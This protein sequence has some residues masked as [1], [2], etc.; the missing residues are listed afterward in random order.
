MD[1]L[2]NFLD[3]EHCV[4][5]IKRKDCRICTAVVDWTQA[6]WS[7]ELYCWSL[8]ALFPCTKGSRLALTEKEALYHVAKW[9]WLFLPFPGALLLLSLLCCVPRTGH[10]DLLTPWTRRCLPS[11]HHSSLSWPLV[12]ASRAWRGCLYAPF[13]MD[14]HECLQFCFISCVT[15]VFINKWHSLWGYL[16]VP[17]WQG[18]LYCPVSRGRPAPL[19]LLCWWLLFP[20][21]ACSLWEKGCS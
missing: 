12:G 2:E 17:M 19:L 6:L 5:N 4:L 20:L 15:T 16:V 13:V 21:W 10:W 3:F 8:I 18:L 14:V 9:N 7:S 11:H 1:F